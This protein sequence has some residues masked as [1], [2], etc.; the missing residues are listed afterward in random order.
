MSDHFLRLLKVPPRHS[1]FLFGPRMTGKSTWLKM[2][3]P[4]ALHI[5]LL[6]EAN[7]Q[8]YL[9]QPSRIRSEIDA[10]RS[11]NPKGWVILDEIQRNPALL[12]EV[13][14]AIEET[15]LKFALSGSSARKLKRGGANLLAGRAFELR[16]FPLTA[17]EWGADFRLDHVL[18]WGALPAV[19]QEENTQKKQILRAYVSTYL[20][21]EI[22]AEGFVRNLPS[23]SR[24]LQLAAETI[25]QETAYS[26]MSRETT[27]AS[28]TIREYY[29]I[30]EDTLLGFLLLPWQSRVQKQLAGSPKFY[31]FDCG[32]TNALRES[33]SDPPTGAEKGALFEQ[34]VIQ[35][36]RAL[37]S[38]QNFE[39]SVAYW[40]ARGGNEVDL[41]IARGRK[42]LLAVEIKS[43]TNP[44]SRDFAGLRSFAEEYP[45]VPKVLVTSQPRASLHDKVE[46]LPYLEFFE[47]LLSGEWLGL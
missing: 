3:F 14:R 38:Y 27:V 9:S 1:F 46:A 16:M 34:W 33:L 47:R 44:S 40:K 32:V 21:E 24:F 11:K 35:E 29:Q 42:P 22:Q 45:K 15:Q 23:F 43:T 37:L 5:D 18:R 2:A 31:F 20:R 4:K 10:F 6:E 19:I 8:R 7:F 41:I 28:K 30:L 26:A 17:H 36:V 12:N 25:G 13:H 39:G